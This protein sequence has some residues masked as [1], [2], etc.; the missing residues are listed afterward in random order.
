MFDPMFYKE[1]KEEITRVQTHFAELENEIEAAYLRWE[2]FENIE[3]EFY[4]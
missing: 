3:K 2:A 1:G 4:A